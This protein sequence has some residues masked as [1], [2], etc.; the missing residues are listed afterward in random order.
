MK[1]I[2]GDNKFNTSWAVN[3]KKNRVKLCESKL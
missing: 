2:D 1:F 3:Y